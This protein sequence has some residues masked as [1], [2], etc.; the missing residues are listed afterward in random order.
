M[1]LDPRSGSLGPGGGGFLHL[2]LLVAHRPVDHHFGAGPEIGWIMPDAPHEDLLKQKLV[3]PGI[4]FW[5][6][7]LRSRLFLGVSAN[8]WI[9]TL[10]ETWFVNALSSEARV[11]ITL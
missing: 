1:H 6:S 10:G 5:Y 3:T 8:T 11:G 2:D 7:A 4:G 9:S